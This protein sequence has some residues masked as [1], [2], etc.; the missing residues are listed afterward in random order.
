MTDG[1]VSILSVECCVAL[2]CVD[3]FL[4][5]IFNGIIFSYISDKQQRLSVPLYIDKF[6]LH[7]FNFVFGEI[8]LALRFRDLNVVISLCS[9]EKNSAG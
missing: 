8:A 6:C 7:C 5:D 2:F 9:P 1:G 3:D 4:L